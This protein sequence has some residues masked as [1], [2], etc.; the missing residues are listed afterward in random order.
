MMM[1][2]DGDAVE[3]ARE[4]A[5]GYLQVHCAGW[6]QHKR[7]P[8]E[9]FT[10]AAEHGLCGLLVAPEQGGRGINF[11]TLIRVVETLAYAD[12]SATFALI[13]HNNHVRAI[14]SSGSP[15]QIERWLPD[16]ISGNM[17]GAFLLTEPGGGSD[18]AAI[19]TA[20]IPDG[21]DYLLNGE[22]TWITNATQA[23]L[24]N[25]FAQTDPSLGSRGIASFQIPADA[26]GVERLPAFE[27]LGGYAMGAG[28]FRFDNVQVS[29]DQL[30][31]PPGMGFA[32]AMSGID[33]ARAVVAG[34]C[35]GILQSSI[36]VA[37]PRLLQR[38]AFG[39]PLVNQQGLVW[40]VADVATQLS[41]SR[42]LAREAARLIDVGEAAAMAAAHAKKFATAAAMDGVAACMQ[43]MGADGLKQSF[44]FAR[45][46]SAAKIAQYIDG[47][48]EIQNVVIS[49]ALQRLY[50]EED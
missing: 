17:I 33:I 12:F 5:A 4:F 26:P 22:K 48:T 15:A 13:V 18:A 37:M 6:E 24:L 9:M 10:A 45:H 20:A 21:G 35:C 8:R 16:M 39:G 1:A 19:T 31:V 29:A 25:V 50:S 49:R 27:M 42:L 36:D 28:A 47:T 11:A 44:P 23:D 14:G 7:M 2:V 43:A 3:A 46:L 32:A 40:Q 30:L 41:A 34:M 38:H